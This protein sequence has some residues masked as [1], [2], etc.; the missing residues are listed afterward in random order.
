MTRAETKH[1]K[2]GKPPRPP[3]VPQGLPARDL[4]VQLVSDVLI[5]R[6]PFDQA[7]S[8]LTARP[9]IVA[10]EPRDR[11]L[12][13]LIAATVLRR[14]GELEQMLNAFLAKPLP[15]E[16]GRLWPILLTGAAQLVCLGMPPHAVVDIAVEL[17]GR[18]RGAHRFAKLANAVLRRVGERGATLSAGQD[19]VRLNTPDWLWQRWASHYG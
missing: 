3:R 19:G 11:A 4:A 14:Q 12:A 17:T 10:L 13:R 8:E 5:G 9:A 15:A 18:D 2:Q 7:W 16:K 1:N 6:Q